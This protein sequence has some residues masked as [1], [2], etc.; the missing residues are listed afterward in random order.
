MPPVRMPETPQA[1]VLMEGELDKYTNNIMFN[2]WQTKYFELF[3]DRIEYQSLGSAPESLD[4]PGAEKGPR[5]V[6]LDCIQDA[7]IN[8]SQTELTLFC[9]TRKIELRARDIQSARDW[10]DAILKQ[11]SKSREHPEKP[12]L[13]GWLEKKK[14]SSSIVSY[15]ARFFV[16]TD[17]ALVYFTE[18]DGNTVPTQAE[19]ESVPLKQRV[20]LANVLDVS[21]PKSAGSSGYTFVVADGARMLKLR[22]DSMIHASDW[23]DKIRN[24]VSANQGHR[25]L[26]NRRPPNLLDPSELLTPRILIQLSRR[27]PYELRPK[28]WALAYSPHAHGSH[29]GTMYHNCK[30]RG[31]NLMIIQDTRGAIFGVFAA[32]PYSPEHKS[33]YGQGTCFVFHVDPDDEDV[34]TWAWSEKNRF[35]VSA[36][37]SHIGVGGGDG[38]FALYLD[39]QLA[40]GSSNPSATFSNPVLASEETFK[41]HLLELWCFVSSETEHQQ[42]K[43]QGE[44]HRTQSLLLPDCPSHTAMNENA[45]Q[46]RQHRSSLSPRGCSKALLQERSKS[47]AVGEL[48]IP[49]RPHLAP[50]E[51]TPPR[52]ER[53]LSAAEHAGP[54]ATTVEPN[55]SLVHSCSEDNIAHVMAACGEDSD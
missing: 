44:L 46:S 15:Q 28:S 45:I 23:V 43:E 13:F 42:V 6:R 17:D 32:Q 40:K 4:S 14:R 47:V 33:Y 11:L 41:V 24:A 18:L 39:A 25:H 54:S 21:N 22:T 16:L 53:R 48:T 38:G 10:V 35:L 7:R 50:L 37:L 12:L 3:E 2:R 5:V 51:R 49:T 8:K 36:S 20:D 31:A 27:L 29:L 34:Q 30:G 52:K 19:I 9:L 26:D 1:R 55:V